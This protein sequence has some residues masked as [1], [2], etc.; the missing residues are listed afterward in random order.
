MT[1]TEYGILASPLDARDD[2]GNV[3]TWPWL[4]GSDEQVALDL[5]DQLDE[6][7]TLSAGT[8]ALTLWRI[9]L[10]GKTAEADVSG[11]SLVGAATVSGTVVLQRLDDLA[12]GRSY[13]LEVLHGAAAN[14][15]GASLLIHCPA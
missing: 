12:R 5:A 15:R 13:R 2:A 10:D 4:F 9:G 11:T 1:V 3:L 6:G 8:I 14:R 7:E